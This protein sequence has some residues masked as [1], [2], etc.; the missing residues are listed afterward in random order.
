MNSQTICEY[1]GDLKSR[2][3]GSSTWMK[4]VCSCGIV[5]DLC[6]FCY[7]YCRIKKFVEKVWIFTRGEEERL[8]ACP[9]DLR[10]AD[11]MTR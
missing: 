2:W 5:H 1:C 7:Q 11:R 9:K 4:I 6:P 3:D 8:I 10:V